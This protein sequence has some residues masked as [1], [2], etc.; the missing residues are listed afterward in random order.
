MKERLYIKGSQGIKETLDLSKYGTPKSRGEADVYFDNVNSRA[1][2]VFKGPD[3]PDIKGFK[4]DEDTAEEKIKLMKEKLPNF[5]QN[6]PK[7]VITPKELARD[8]NDRILGYTMRYV[9]GANEL[10]NYSN[11]SFHENAGLSNEKANEIVLAVFRDLHHTVTEI[12]EADVVIG[13]FSD[14]N[15]LVKEN[16]AYIID[17]DSFQFGKYR[18]TM[19]KPDFLDPKLIEPKGKDLNIK[20]GA[21]QTPDTDWY[22]Y[23]VMLLQSLLLVKPYGGTYKR[24]PL[25]SP[26]GRLK[27]R[28]TIFNKEVELP[29]DIIPHYMLPDDLIQHFEDVF[30]KKDKRGE[31]PDYLLDMKWKKCGCG[32][33]HSRA[34]CPKHTTTIPKK[35]IELNEVKVERI[36]EREDIHILASAYQNNQLRYLYR[37]ADEYK[38]EDGNILFKSESYPE[39]RYEIQGKNTIVKNATHKGEPSDFFFDPQDETNISIP[40]DKLKTNSDAMYHISTDKLWRKDRLGNITSSESLKEESAF[41]VGEDFGIVV[42]KTSKGIIPEF[43]F[44]A[45]NLNSKQQIT[46][47]WEIE[48]QLIDSDCYFDKGISW[49]FTSMKKDSGTTNYCTVI[50][51][52]GEQ[53]V[54]LIPNSKAAK[55]SWICNIH[56]KCAINNVLLTPTDNGIRK[57]IFDL[58]SKESIIEKN[59]I[60]SE[61]ARFVNSRT[62]LLRGKDEIYAVNEQDIVR[63]D[64]FKEKEIDNYFTTISIQVLLQNKADIVNEIINKTS[65]GQPGRVEAQK[66]LI[67]LYVIYTDLKKDIELRWVPKYITGEDCKGLGVITQEVAELLKK[68]TVISLLGKKVEAETKAGNMTNTD[69]ELAHIISIIN[70]GRKKEIDWLV[71]ELDKNLIINYNSPGQK[72]EYLENLSPDEAKKKEIWMKEAVEFIEKHKIA[73]VG[74]K[75]FDRQREE[76]EREL[77]RQKEEAEKELERQRKEAFIN[78]IRE[79]KIDPTQLKEQLNKYL[80][81]ERDEELGKMYKGKSKEEIHQAWIIKANEFFDEYKNDP[82][83]TAQHTF[84]KKILKQEGQA[85]NEVVVNADTFF[86]TFFTGKDA[87]DVEF[88]AKKIAD[89]NTREEIEQNKDLI[90]RLAPMYGQSF[91][92]ISL[93]YIKNILDLKEKEASEELKKEFQGALDNRWNKD[94][95]ENVGKIFEKVGKTLGFGKETDTIVTNKKKVNE[96]FSELFRGGPDALIKDILM[97]SCGL[98]EQEASA[99]M[100]DKVLAEKMRESVV[101]QLVSK[102]IQAG[103]LTAQEVLYIQNSDW[104]KYA[105]NKILAERDKVKGWTG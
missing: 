21:K 15:V 80:S 6:L 1:V 60:Y 75:E 3:H 36:F 30:S 40:R 68:E 12:H 14:D 81:K 44:D 54:R 90:P 96:D 84:L 94:K 38:R 17:A 41:W 5:P 4:G 25:I 53:I 43:V 52:K 26:E 55:D 88:F 83:K 85:V 22:A 101:E 51:Q 63:L 74:K 77:K 47:T 37:E 69:S 48:G 7:R 61:T 32:A 64:F 42:E 18:S 99:K 10:G 58:K 50:N 86:N 76:S 70:Y 78:D 35:P 82:T 31:F 16:K 71:K 11:P 29:E 79:N 93:A 56:G 34:A 65:P 105:M 87:T 92:K 27:N 72:K 28:I 49:L 20:E 23:D 57:T 66:E 67:K 98:S 2:K 103:Q 91:K 102:G 104:G 97:T 73:F 8:E 59:T 62:K 24:D 100:K 39:V 13:D 33:E 89:T 45:R 95:K 46:N 19:F 9:D